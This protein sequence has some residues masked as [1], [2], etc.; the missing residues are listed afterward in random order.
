MKKRFV[1]AALAVLALAWA[2]PSA[3]DTISFDT[4]GAGAGGVIDATI[5]DWLP[6]NSLI[7]ETSPTTAT[8]YYQAN[9]GVIQTT[10]SPGGDYLNCTGGAG[11]CFTAVAYFDVVLTPTS[12]TSTNYTLVPGSGVLKIYADNERGD[13]LTGLGFA[14]DPGAVEI[15]SAS[16]VSGSG[17]FSFSATADLN[18]AADC[19]ASDPLALNGTWKNCGD[20]IA[21]NDLQRVLDSFN[22][23]VATEPAG[24]NYPGY[25]T[26]AGQGA[27]DITGVVT[28]FNSSYFLNLVAG[29]SFTMTNSSQ[30]DPYN[31]ANPSATF[32]PNAVADGGLAGVSSVCGPGQTPGVNCVNGTGNNI[33]AQADANSEFTLAAP[34]VPEPA[35]LTLLG[36]GLAGSAMARRRQKKNA[37]KS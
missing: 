27:A 35:S 12:P 2:R 21:S 25:Y 34:V 1:V 31:Q 26:L 24:N 7:V 10:T 14:L 32:S 22:S 15:L 18:P 17:D 20:G 3:A 11:S 29:S 37:A 36:L 16:I 5:F 6:G 28:S 33:I 30:I 19:S 4:N 23:A 9:L 13:N 8:I